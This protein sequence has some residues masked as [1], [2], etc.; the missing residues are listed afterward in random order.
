MWS[1]ILTTLLLL[2]VHHVEAQAI[3]PDLVVWTTISQW[4]DLRACV[5]G[6]LN[7]NW[8]PGIQHMVGCST[9][10]CLCRPDTLGSA[11]QSLSSEV[12]TLCS[13]VQDI[14]TATSIL[15]SY[16]SAKGYTSIIQPTILASSGACTAV[17]TPTATVTAYVTQYVTASGASCKSSQLQMVKTGVA[18]LLVLLM[19]HSGM[20]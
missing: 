3:D 1:P 18:V 15:L 2:S 8:N 7:G 17:P 13:D 14:S 12:S 5:Q 4:Q 16:C 10:A 20:F 6:A 19:H 9:N 11:E